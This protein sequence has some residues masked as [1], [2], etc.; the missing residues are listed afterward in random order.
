MLS[1]PLSVGATAMSVLLGGIVLMAFYESPL[2]PLPVPPL[3]QAPVGS[4]YFISIAL[5]L[6]ASLCWTPSDALLP[7]SAVGRDFIVA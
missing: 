4:N 3:P 2:S 1:T 7:D 6:I 5:H